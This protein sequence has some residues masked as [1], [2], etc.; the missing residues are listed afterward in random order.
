M[1]VVVKS[2]FLVLLGLNVANILALS[3]RELDKIGKK[4]WQNEASG[5]EELLVFWSKNESFPSLGIGHN[6]WLPAGREFK[7]KEE[8]PLLCD[9]L[10]KKNVKLPDWL[11]KAKETGAPWQS[12]E[13]FYNDRHR[14]DQLRTL[15]TKTIGLQMQFML[16]RLKNRLPYIVE[17][18]PD[19]EREKVINYIDILLS[20]SAGTYVLIDY[21]NFKGD[22]ISFKEE[23][24]GERWG[25]L[26]VLL[27]MP[28]GL[29]KSNIIKSFVL[30]AA[31]R[32]LTLIDHSAPEYRR[33]AFFSGW[34]KRLGTYLN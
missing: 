3:S 20:S 23:S 32:L 12:R 16:E 21:L 31:K 10:K 2:L 29:D 1:K 33:M 13:E 11:E 30:S 9:F 28:E 24:N 4:I 5:R 17:A 14:R 18:A 7:F 22:G 8:F 15:L 25:L 19:E 6:I 27:A 34:M 26:A